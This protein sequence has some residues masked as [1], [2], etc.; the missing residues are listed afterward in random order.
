MLSVANMLFLS[1]AQRSDPK[2][3]NNANHTNLERMGIQYIFSI[4]NKSLP[5]NVFN[6]REE[7][8]KKGGERE[9]RKE[10]NIRINK[11][12]GEKKKKKKRSLANLVVPSA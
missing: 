7:N 11:Y 10:E 6:G 3:A 5:V 9:K 8:K 12:S 1:K 4:H 2:C